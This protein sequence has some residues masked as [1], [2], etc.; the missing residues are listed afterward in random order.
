[1][2]AEERAAD[3]HSD[4]DREDEA[5]VARRESKRGR[6]RQPESE[7]EREPL[8]D[9]DHLERVR[10]R[11]ALIVSCFPNDPR[12]GGECPD[13]RRPEDERIRPDEGKWSHAA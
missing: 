1:M 4:A 9:H 7:E 11:F 5:R 8:P 13:E 2:S 3:H 10:V 6:P 12:L